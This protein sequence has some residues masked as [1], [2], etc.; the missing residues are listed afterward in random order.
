MESMNKV[1]LNI[2]G[3]DYVVT[4]EETPGYIQELGAKVDANIRTL[5]NNNKRTSLV[6]ASVM[7]AIMQADEAK[8]AVQSAD[9]LRKQ[10]KSFFDD[11]N[12]SR[13]ETESL[14]REI[15][16]LKQEKED[17]ERRLADR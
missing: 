7:T 5:M 12:R 17:L 16:R 6:M 13:N 10:L 15:A 3:T 4:T 14:R 11:S 1:T 8:K 2:C 9:N